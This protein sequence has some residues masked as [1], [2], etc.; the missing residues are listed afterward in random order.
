MSGAGQGIRPPLSLLD[1]RLLDHCLESH[2]V[3]ALP[4][5]LPF[6]HEK[7]PHFPGHLLSTGDLL[8]LNRPPEQHLPSYLV[9]P[10]EEL[11]KCTHWSPH[12]ERTHGSILDKALGRPA[13]EA[14]VG[15]CS[16]SPLIFCLTKEHLLA[17][18]RRVLRDTTWKMTF[19]SKGMN[20]SWKN[21]RHQKLSA[22][23]PWPE[24][25]TNGQHVRFHATS[26]PFQ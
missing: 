20:L 24:E 16:A 25:L 12:R 23:R 3:K 5:L 7:L 22:R 14:P 6:S 2:S 18:N 9:D 15:F 17:S 13:E 4:A 21:H 26:G 19:S 11:R 10:W 1:L 8:G